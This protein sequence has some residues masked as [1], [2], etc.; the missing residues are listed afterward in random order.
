MARPGRDPW[1]VLVDEITAC[2]RCPRLRAHCDEVAR[3]KRKAFLGEA[4]WGKPVPG[5]GDRGAR[6]L[7]VG[8]APAAHGANRTGRMFTGDD[9]GNWLYRALHKAGLATSPESRSRDDGLEL[10]GAFITA[11]C[12]CAPPDNKPTPAEMDACATFLDHEVELLPDVE[13]VLALGKIAWDAVLRRAR[14]AAPGVLPRPLPRFAHGAE[15]R[16][17]LRA[18]AAP[19]RL[20]GS[21][22]PS[23]QNTNT[24]RLT[25]PMLDGALSL[26][27][28]IGSRA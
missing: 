2:D 19:I 14:R 15:T 17:V 21:Y 22:H 8:L 27:K 9:S 25:E 24:G 11:T 28:P 7:I 5:F 3:V 16:V 20:V 1:K 26:A 18:G 12:R 4:Y 13:T 6:L 10:R 23:R